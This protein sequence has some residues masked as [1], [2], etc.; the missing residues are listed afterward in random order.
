MHLKALL[1]T[2]YQSWLG[3]QHVCTVENFSVVKVKWFGVAVTDYHIAVRQ[4]S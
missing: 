3:E 2:R 4:V 1:V